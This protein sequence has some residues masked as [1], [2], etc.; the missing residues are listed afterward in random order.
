MVKMHSILKQ[1]T[2]REAS[3]FIQF[4]KYAI[5]GSVATAV[6]IITFYM[7]ALLVLPA[8]EPD[9]VVVTVLRIA[10]VDLTDALRA[11][12]AMINN[13]LAFIISNLTA[14][15]LNIYWV[16]ESGRHHRVIEIGMFYLVSGASII[17]GSILMGVLINYFSLSTTV[18]FIAIMIV[19]VLINYILRKKVIF[20]G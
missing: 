20:K 1:F 14:Y 15:L 8:L 19:S 4:V 12:N 16:F 13:A 11:R 18:A 9:D 6:H 17:L 3:P 7:L 10:V 2:Q 5:A